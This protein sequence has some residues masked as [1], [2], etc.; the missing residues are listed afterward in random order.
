MENTAFVQAL[1]VG[2]LPEILATS[3]P[4]LRLTARMKCMKITQIQM[5]LRIDLVIQQV[6]AVS[7]SN[8]YHI[9]TSMLLVVPP[10]RPRQTLP[11][12]VFLLTNTT[13]MQLPFAIQSSLVPMEISDTALLSL[14]IGLKTK[15]AGA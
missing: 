4:I 12:E 9:E 1:Q 5:Y 14:F 8:H 3:R 15:H 13:S 7:I 2:T 11:H 10:F 6:L